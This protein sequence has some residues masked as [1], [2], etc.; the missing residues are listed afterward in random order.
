MNKLLQNIKEPFQV[1]NQELYLILFIENIKIL[2]KMIL[3]IYIIYKIDKEVIIKYL[4]K[5]KTNEEIKKS[6]KDNNT[7]NK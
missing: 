2:L 3:K 5:I 1:L 4:N 7:S 6:V